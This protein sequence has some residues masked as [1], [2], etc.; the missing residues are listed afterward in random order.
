VHGSV[1]VDLFGRLCALG[2]RGHGCSCRRTLTLI[3]LLMF[4]MCS[5]VLC[6]ARAVMIRI[7]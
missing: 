1:E 6:R 5:N 7:L 4:Q 3:L 2:G